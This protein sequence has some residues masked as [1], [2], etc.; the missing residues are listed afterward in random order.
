MELGI[1]YSFPCFFLQCLLIGLKCDEE[2]NNTVL[3]CAEFLNLSD[4]QLLKSL[5]FS[6][7][8]PS[9]LK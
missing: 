7:Q 8:P 3:K 4:G 1:K 5:L 9:S 2:V 6:F